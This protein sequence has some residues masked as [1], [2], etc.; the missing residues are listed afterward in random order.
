MLDDNYDLRANHLISSASFC[1]INTGIGP[2]EKRI[3]ALSRLPF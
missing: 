1:F 2:A 3:K